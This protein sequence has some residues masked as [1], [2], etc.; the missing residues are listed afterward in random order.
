MGHFLGDALYRYL[1][2]PGSC[3]NLQEAHHSISIR[4]K[5][6]GHSKSHVQV[7]QLVD[8]LNEHVFHP[9][10]GQ[11]EEWTPWQHH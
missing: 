1:Y 9:Y 7:S 3:I 10:Y 2:V 8:V 4:L 6:V 5:G 11:G